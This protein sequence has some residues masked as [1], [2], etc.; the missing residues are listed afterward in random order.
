MRNF[1]SVEFFSPTDCKVVTS[2]YFQT[3]RGARNWAKWCAKSF[4]Q[5]RIMKGGP[6]GMEVA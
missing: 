6:G 1:Y 4:S 3:L 5:V 2:R